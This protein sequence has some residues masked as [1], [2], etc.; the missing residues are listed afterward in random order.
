MITRAPVPRKTTTGCTVTVEDAYADY[1]DGVGYTQCV[2]A[3][4]GNAC[5]GAWSNGAGKVV[6]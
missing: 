5:V 1:P 6:R 4:Y 2:G 3:Q